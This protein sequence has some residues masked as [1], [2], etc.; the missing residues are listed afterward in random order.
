[1][2][3][4]YTITLIILND[5]NIYVVRDVGYVATAETYKHQL[6][7]FMHYMQTSQYR[8]QLEREISAEQQRQQ[9][10]RARVQYLETQMSNLQKESMA[11]LKSRLSE[12]P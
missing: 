5:C 12:V 11:Q 7:T 9:Q 4:R 3:G 1:M 6:L 2:T 8:E 10:L